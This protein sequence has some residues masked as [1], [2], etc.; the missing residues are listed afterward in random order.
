VTSVTP[1]RRMMALAI[2]LPFMPFEARTFDI[3]A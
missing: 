2:E 3:W 1:F